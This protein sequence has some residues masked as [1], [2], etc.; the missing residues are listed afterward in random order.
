MTLPT[1]S[2]RFAFVLAAI[3]GA[4]GL[5]NIWRFPYLTGTHGG[6]AFVAVYL[7]CVV[8]IALPILIAE[9]MIGRQGRASPPTAMANMA[10]DN[11]RS[12]RWSLV[13][14]LGAWAGFLIVS[15]YS[16][17]G[18][19]TLAYVQNAAS[20]TLTGIDSARSSAL[21]DALTGSPTALIAWH[22]VFMAVTVGIVA[23]GLNRGIEAAVRVLM[24]ALFVML[25]AMVGYALAAGNVTRT[26][27]FLFR[28]D[29]AAI[30]GTVI[31]LAIGQAFFSIGVAMGLMMMYGA[32]LAPGQPLPRYAV[33]IALADTLVAVLAGLAIF[34]LVFAYGLDPAEGPGLIFVALPLAFGNMPLGIPFGALFFVLLVVAAV[35]SA[36]ALIQPMV[37]RVGERPSMTPTRAALLVGG[38]AWLLGIVSALCFNVLRDFHPLGW[39]PWVAGRNI[40]QWLDFVT[41]NV[42]MPLGGVL[43]AV[44]AG[45]L[46]P[47]AALQRA[48]PGWHGPAS[49]LWRV[50]VRF[51]APAAI[52]AIF[53]ANLR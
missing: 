2:T 50:A 41:A 20:G 40:Y 21:F 13:G 5:G 26:M 33:I 34:P 19:W 44:F 37:A 45:W 10:A 35:T 4:V 53:L 42:M 52:L 24:P 46:V 12:R 7:V 27:L 31:L 38:G 29:V 43:I 14:W 49:R 30:D 32:Y 28:F 8:L 39:L 23:R 47:E 51:V 17:I 3:G 9:L 22:T 16:V 15:Y 48:L 11:G 6:G 1:W 18:G 36:I 25:L